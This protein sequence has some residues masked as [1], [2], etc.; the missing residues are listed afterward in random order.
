MTLLVLNFCEIG[1]PLIILSW[2]VPFLLG[3]LL[4]FGIW[5]RF[6]KKSED[7]AEEIV[8]LKS[9]IVDLKAEV[10]KSHH[11]V[12]EVESDMASVKGQLREKI[13]QVSTLEAAIEAGK[14]KKKGGKDKDL[15]G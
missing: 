11:K 15:N 14:K 1:L 6:K 2:L 9:N 8:G 7:L 4:G 10:E 3:L 13:L 12:T 5:G